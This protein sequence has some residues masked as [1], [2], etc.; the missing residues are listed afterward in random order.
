M[1][2]DTYIILIIFTRPIIIDIVNN[3][4]I[5]IYIVNVCT[6]IAWVFFYSQFI[7]NTLKLMI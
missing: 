7:D 4:S 3:N 5:Y 1:V 6:V 2:A